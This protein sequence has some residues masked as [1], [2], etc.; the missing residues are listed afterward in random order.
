MDLRPEPAQD[1]VHE[2]G[3]YPVT[4]AESIQLTNAEATVL[5]LVLLALLLMAVALGVL[6]VLGCVWAYRAGRGSRRAR[7]GWIIVGSFEGLV[8][9]GFLPALVGRHPNLLVL[10]PIVALVIQVALYLFGRSIGPRS[11]MP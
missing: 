6:A 8:M 3:D 7:Q 11:A 9:L 1:A 10:V 4:L 2:R 5:L